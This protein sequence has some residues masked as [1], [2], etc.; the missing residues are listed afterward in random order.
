MHD[1]CSY[2]SSSHTESIAVGYLLHALGAKVQQR[3]R[4]PKH[5]VELVGIPMV[6]ELQF[7]N[8]T[9]HD[10]C[11]SES[12]NIQ[13]YNLELSSCWSLSGSADV[14]IPRYAHPWQDPHDVAEIRQGRRC[15]NP[16]TKSLLP[17]ARNSETPL[18]FPATIRRQHRL[19][20]DLHDVAPPILR[21][22]EQR[23]R[24]LPRVHLRR[25]RADLQERLHH[26][27]EAWGGGPFVCLTREGGAQNSWTRRVLGGA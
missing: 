20:R 12:T 17:R 14:P 6:E 9:R 19:R 5:L 24:A 4:H 8:H 1:I 18:H 21:R 10:S 25:V 22:G 13:H 11:H 16:S 3:H 7:K 26:L 2:P 27:G 15:S 23:E